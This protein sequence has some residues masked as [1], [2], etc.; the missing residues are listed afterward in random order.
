MERRGGAAR[1]EQDKF[2]NRTGRMRGK[3]T[4]DAIL[5][6]SLIHLRFTS[7]VCSP[8]QNPA[9]LL[10]MTLPCRGFEGSI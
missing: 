1:Q 9:D 2:G 10:E 7:H 6:G 4:D 5:R 8:E 3:L